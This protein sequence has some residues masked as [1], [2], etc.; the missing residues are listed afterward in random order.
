MKCGCV[1]LVLSEPS[2]PLV[3]GILRLINPFSGIT[4]G[5]GRPSRTD[6]AA[7]VSTPIPMNMMERLRCV[8][9]DSPLMLLGGDTLAFTWDTASGPLMPFNTAIVLV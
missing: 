6:A 1:V 2:L 7:A 5:I 3:S 8:G 4:R 9:S